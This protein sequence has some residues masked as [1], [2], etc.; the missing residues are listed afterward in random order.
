MRGIP[1]IPRSRGTIEVNRVGA[2]VRFLRLMELPPNMIA[3]VEEYGMLVE[4]KRV[5]PYERPYLEEAVRRIVAYSPL[6]DYRPRK[7]TIPT[8]ERG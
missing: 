1:C 5:R 3:A 2:V 6:L 4:K 8:S 7:Q